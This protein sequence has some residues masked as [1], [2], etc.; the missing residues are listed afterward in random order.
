[1]TKTNKNT[2]NPPVLTL[3]RLCIITLWN[4][5]PAHL[6]LPVSAAYRRIQDH[7]S[8]HSVLLLIY[9]H[10]HIMLPSLF[11]LTHTH[12][13]QHISKERCGFAA[14]HSI[15]RG[16]IFS[17]FLTWAAEVLIALLSWQ[18]FQGKRCYP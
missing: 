11:S 2:H 5:L 14:D 17:S 4:T 16:E 13:D 15:H 6:S 7:R 18:N 12:T 8:R 1:M 10:S 3:R 9:I